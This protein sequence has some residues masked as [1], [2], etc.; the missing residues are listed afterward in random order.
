MNDYGFSNNGMNMGMNEYEWLLPL[1]IQRQQGMGMPQGMPSSQGMPS[2]QAPPSQ[3]PSLTP[4]SLYNM[5]SP[6]PTMP[7][8]TATSGTTPKKGWGPTADAAMIGASMAMPSMLGMLQKD[9]Y[10]VPP[11]DVD[12][13]NAGS[14][15][16]KTPFQMP[17]IFR[18]QPS[19][20]SM[21]ASYLRR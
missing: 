12:M 5:G 21:L 1:L 11:P 19:F 14:V 9:P 10:R 15:G 2:P 16:M 3:M 13:P 20:K 7:S 17:Q 6:S 4:N 8:P 18:P